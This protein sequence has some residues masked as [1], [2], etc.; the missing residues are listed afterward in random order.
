[1]NLKK[2]V[3]CSINDYASHPSAQTSD[4]NVVGIET[5]TNTINNAYTTTNY[6]VRFEKSLEDFTCKFMFYHKEL[7]ELDV[8]NIPYYSSPNLWKLRDPINNLTQKILMTNGL[9]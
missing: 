7:A 2:S 3:Y 9:T 1:M 5:A 6:T 8:T 4:P